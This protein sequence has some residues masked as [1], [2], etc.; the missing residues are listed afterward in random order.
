MDTGKMHGPAERGLESPRE[1]QLRM[2]REDA[3]TFE[4]WVIDRDYLEPG[5]DGRVGYGQRAEENRV[6]DFHHVTV[7]RGLKASEVKDPVRFRLKDDDD[8]V[9]YGGAISRSWIDGDEDLAFSPLAFGAADAGC[10]ELEYHY[11]DG[12]W[13]GL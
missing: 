13:K 12:A 9:Y 4:G 11:G 7:T 5:E 1:A 10:T 3:G 6:S 8:E 2:A